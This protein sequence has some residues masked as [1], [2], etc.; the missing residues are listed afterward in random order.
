MYILEQDVFSIQYVNVIMQRFYRQLPHRKSGGIIQAPINFLHLISP[1]SI[2]T[3]VER[4][5][6]NTIG[7]KEL[8][9]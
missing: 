9:G 7:G 4:Y 2:T 3:L 1:F 8:V 5:F 6:R